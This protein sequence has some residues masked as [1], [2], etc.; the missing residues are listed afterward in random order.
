MK[1]LFSALLLAGAAMA[2]PAQ[3]T[4]SGR[5]LD[6]KAFDL[7]ERRGRVVLL[8]LW[9]TDCAVCLNKMPEPTRPAGGT[10]LSIW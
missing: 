9:R 7:A 10:S 4:L 5:T 6:G 3:T 2:A 1:H 8:L